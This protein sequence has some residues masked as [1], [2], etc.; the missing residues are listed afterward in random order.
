LSDLILRYTRKTKESK[1]FAQRYRRVLADP[2]VV[3]GFRSQWKEMVYP[4]VVNRSRGSR[5]WD[6]DGND[7]ID[8]LNGFGPITFG[9]LPDFVTSAVSQQLAEGIE[10]GPQSPLAGPVAELLCEL[11]G[12]ERATFC[13]TGSEAVMAALRLARTVTGRKLV[14]LFAGDYH[15]NFEEVLVKRTGRGDSLRSGP[16]APGIAAEAVANV[17]VLDYGSSEALRVIRE[18]ANELA[19]VLVEPV[20]SR[21]PELRPAEFLREVRRITAESGT[22]LIFDEIVTGFRVHRGGAQAMYGIQADL[23]TF[24]KILGGGLPI[25]AVAGKAAFMDAL[26]GGFWSYGDDSY[27]ETGMTF[28]A[29]T[30]VRHPLALAAALAVLR[31]MKESGTALQE[32]LTRKTEALVQ[33]LNAIFLRHGVP[34]EIRT[35]GSWF[36]FNFASDFPYGSLLFFE[37]RERGVHIL[38]GFPCFLTTAHS[39]ADLR[40]IEAAFESSCQ[41][42]Q[43]GDI[44]PKNVAAPLSSPAALTS[45]VTE[46]PLTE[47]Q[48]EIWVSTQLGP[49]AACAYNESLSIRFDGPLDTTALNE[50]FQQVVARHDALRAT[51]IPAS[52]GTGA[53]MRFAPPGG[54]SIPLVD[55]RAYSPAEAESSLASSIGQDAK[56]PFDLING[57]VFRAELFRLSAASHVLLF[58]AHHIVCD[59]W[60]VNV[61]VDEISKVYAAKRAGTNPELPVPLSYGEYARTQRSNVDSTQERS[62]EEYWLQRFKEPAPVLDLPVDRPRPAFK[63]YAGSTYRQTISRELYQSIK[64]AGSRQGATLMATLLAGFESLLFRLSGQYDVVV[65]IP[66]AAQSLLD[67][68]TLVGHCVNFLPVRATKESG[69]TFSELLEQTRASLLDA[70]DHQTYTFGTLVRKLDLKRSPSRLPLIEVQFNLERVGGNASFPDLQVRVTSNPKAAVNFDLFLNAVE[71]PDGLVLDCDYNSDLFDQATIERWLDHYV[72]LLAASANDPACPVANLPLLSHSQ[73][74]QLIRGQNQTAADYPRDKRIHDWFEEQVARSPQSPA[75]AFGHER[76]TY[77]QLN[78]R[79]NRLARYLSKHGAGPGT[80]VAIYLERTLPVPEALLAVLK[81][82]AAYVPLDPALPLERTTMILESA[83]AGLILTEERDALPLAPIDIRMICLDAEKK[84]IQ[85]ESDAPFHRAGSAEAPAYVIFT[86]GSTGKPK[87]VEVSHR[88]VVNFLASMQREPGMAPRDK[89]LAVTTLSFDIAGLEMFLPLVSGAEVVIA[90]R[91]TT[92][93]GALL[94]EMIRRFGINVLQATPVTWRLLLD[95]GWQ[96]PPGFRMLCGGEALPRQLANRLLESSQELWNLYGPTET[97]IWSAVGRVRAGEGPVLIGPPIANTQFYILDVNGQVCPFGVSGEL[98]IGGDGVAAGYYRQPALTHEKFI[99]DPFHSDP[100][101]RLYKSGDLVRKL[102]SNDLEFLGR[103]DHQVKIRG[104]RI[105][106]GEIEAAIAQQPGVSEVVVLLQTENPGDER[107]V[108]Y[109]AGEVDRLPTNRMLREALN[110]KLPSY[111]VPAQFAH[112]ESMPRTGN[113]KIDVNGLKTL[114]ITIVVEHSDF[115][116]PRSAAEETLASIAA[117]VL[118]LP[119]VGVEDNLFELGA[120]SL[121]IFQIAARAARAEIPMTAQHL[122]RGRTLAAALLSASKDAGNGSISASKLRHITRAPREVYRLRGTNP[123]L[124]KH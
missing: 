120:D 109:I 79:A 11:T 26:D 17:I 12:M 91:D 61:L 46:A 101:A 29:G 44:W 15:G 108:A 107:L 80:T 55:L 93:D 83:G 86:S 98:H 53:S 96:A 72:T 57:P 65:G 22:A 39:E 84:A 41:A 13:N 24:G 113:G 106:L 90:N 2:R 111:M 33:E 52:D 105:E 74:Q 30:F 102:P 78:A 56:T 123:L 37:L 40:M 48:L 28:F 35:C 27:P 85:K 104:F 95:A 114:P 18:R 88:S 38:E 63:S 45:A 124:A 97:T 21:H 64:Q 14:V 36:Y 31:H 69:T 62:V 75:V 77:A 50:S 51:F 19:A 9:H 20:Q 8:L 103:L 100:G 118:Q 92:M 59:G 10:I 54:V 94:A 116:A 4:I 66:A 7:Y 110:A 112:L 5:L 49:E 43:A 89:L 121:R 67:G 16:I 1:S 76:L 122:L 68:K 73:L 119:R 42:M 60:S 117:E 71:S 6:V 99:P 23:A 34:S 115:V 70:Y 47:A 32:D 81:C 3:S 25:G 58:T 82:G 87:G